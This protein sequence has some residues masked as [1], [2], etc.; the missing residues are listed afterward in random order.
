MSMV[1]MQQISKGVAFLKGI[2]NSAGSFMGASDDLF[3]KAQSLGINETKIKELQS[4][5]RGR[6]NVI[7][8]VA[9]KT[10][11]NG[12]KVAGIRLVEGGTVKSG[13]I[14]GG[15]TI[16]HGNISVSGLDEGKA[17]Y[18]TRAA[19][20]NDTIYGSAFLDT[21]APID[22]AG[23]NKLTLSLNNGVV[24]S[25][26]KC[27]KFAAMRGKADYPTFVKFMNAEGEFNNAIDAVNA[28]LKDEITP[29]LK[30]L[31]GTNPKKWWEFVPQRTYGDTPDVAFDKLSHKIAESIK[32]IL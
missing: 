1:A 32:S 23:A 19:I 24:E 3:A 9:W 13:G 11:K 28:G 22:I 4:L 17:V 20:G 10:S 31:N 2:K 18:K 21:T 5:L 12:Y 15:N 29:F 8:K 6:Q 7:G 30:A 14:K 25:A 26:V 16:F 27:G